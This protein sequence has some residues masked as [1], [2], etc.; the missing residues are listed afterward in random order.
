MTFWLKIFSL[1]ATLREL[2]KK[3]GEGNFLY[4]NSEDVNVYLAMRSELLKIAKTTNSCFA[5]N[6]SEL[7][8]DEARNEVCNPHLTGHD[9]TTRTLKSW[10]ISHGRKASTIFIFSTRKFPSII[11]ISKKKMFFHF[12]YLRMKAN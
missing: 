5:V 7:F 9:K 6:G 11:C 4:G 8:Y 10:K 2:G 12:A 1:L 3:N